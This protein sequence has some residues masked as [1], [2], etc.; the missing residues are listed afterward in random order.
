MR[1]SDRLCLAPPAV[2][3]TSN[4]VCEFFS[5]R[6]LRRLPKSKIGADQMLRRDFAKAGLLLVAERYARAARSLPELKI[7]DVRAIPTSAAGNHSWV[8]L[9]VMTSE[10]GLYG[11]GSASNIN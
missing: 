5:R 7:T 9:K 4:S 3:A 6:R 1:N 11:I 2:N 10:P 8:F